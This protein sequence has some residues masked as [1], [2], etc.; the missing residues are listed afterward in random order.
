MDDRTT[1]TCFYLPSADQKTPV[2]ETDPLP[3]VEVEEE[4]VHHEGLSLARHLLSGW[5]VLVVLL[6]PLV[7]L[8]LALSIGEP[9]S[10]LDLIDILPF[11][12]SVL[13]L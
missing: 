11:C 7:L 3:E 10:L 8:P 13:S 2:E 6:L 5:Y 9:V 12:V 1:N 4:D